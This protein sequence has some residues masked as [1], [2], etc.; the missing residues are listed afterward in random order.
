MIWIFFVIYIHNAAIMEGAM[1]EQLRQQNP[2]LSNRRLCVIGGASG[3]GLAIATAA[4]REGAK[5]FVTG[6]S[7]NSLASAGET[8]GMAP[9][10]VF[11]TS[12]T[13]RRSQLTAQISVHSTR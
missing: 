5:V 10:P 7:Q 6:T 2:G 12:V 1:D 9:K 11:S 3:I 8:L 4:Q 13:A